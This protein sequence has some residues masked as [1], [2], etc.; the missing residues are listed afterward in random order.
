M[1]RRASAAQRP[2]GRLALL[3]GGLVLVGGIAV[4][5][6]SPML[7]E[8]VRSGRDTGTLVAEARRNPADTG[9]L[10][11][12]AERL[13][14]DA[15]SAEAVEILAPHVRPDA[16]PRLVAT[17]GR[18]ALEA[19]RLRQAAEWL[20]PAATRYAGDPDVAVSVALL[21]RKR[22]DQDTARKVLEEV[23]RGHPSHRLA[24]LKLGELLLDEHDFDGA[25][26][27]LGKVGASAEANWL[28]AW[29]LWNLGRREEAERLAR[30]AAGDRPCGPSLT[31]L[32]RILQQSD[33]TARRAEALRIL[34]RVTALDPT[35]ASA[36]RLVGISARDTGDHPLAIRAFRRAV[37]LDPWNMSAYQML[38]QSYQRR[39][40]SAR[41]G[42]VWAIVNRLEPR[43]DRVNSTRFLANVHRNAL[44]PVVEL[45]AAYRAAGRLTEARGV[46]AEAERRAAAAGPAEL[47]ALAA[48]RKAQQSARE[49]PP[50][51][52]PADP[53]GDA[54]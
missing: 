29:A 38:A 39:G 26:S 51:A 25:A 45:A 14:E 24:Q 3:V 35:S 22:N 31:T 50:P 17:A 32:G 20:D 15:R 18:A 42:A 47:S 9:L 49:T 2:P 10:V 43:M 27:L 7:L 16:D 23:V 34:R 12:A 11:L 5:R 46:L 8:R 13:I 41:A 44:A 21:L 4:W 54:E 6:L 52:L 37:G 28:R 36:W 48:E 30:R 40:D 19:G 53:E 1:S 33:D